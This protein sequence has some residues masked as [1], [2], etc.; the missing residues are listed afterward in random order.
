MKLRGKHN[1]MNTMAAALAA[2]NAGVSEQDIV[3][4]LKEFAGVEHRLEFV[5]EK[6]GIKFINDSKATTVESLFFALQSF[7]T[8][9]ILITGGMDKGSDF[10]KLNDLIKKYVKEIVLIGTSTQK[11]QK[12]WQGIKPIFAAKTLEEAVQVAKQKALENEVVLLSP[13]C[14]SFDMFS[15]F[16]ERGRKFKEI[17]NSF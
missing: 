13:A 2:K 15:D 3:K 8:P 17:V 14:A 4:V 1:Y 11:M 10:T 12:A 9:I 16:E 7:P 5:A 6:E